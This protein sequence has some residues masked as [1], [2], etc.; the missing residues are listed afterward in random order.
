MDLHQFVELRF[1][2]FGKARVHAD[3]RIV[4]QKVEALALPAASELD[5]QRLDES[6]NARA[7]SHVEPQS[8]GFPSLAFDFAQYGLC[9]VRAGA[10]GEDAIHPALGQM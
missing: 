2:R 10:I 8:N 4:D 9:F 5:L 6:P 1:G 3:A 7:I